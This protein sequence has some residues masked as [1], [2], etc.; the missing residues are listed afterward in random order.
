MGKLLIGLGTVVVVLVLAF[1]LY[2]RWAERWTSGVAPPPLA[3]PAS[4][5]RPAPSGGSVSLAQA[6]LAQEQQRQAAT[7]PSAAASA[8]PGAAT[9]P[10]APVA[11]SARGCENLLV[12]GTRLHAWW[13]GNG[14]APEAALVLR[15]VRPEGDRGDF[16]ASFTPAGSAAQEPV[17]GRWIG[18][19][20]FLTRP[21]SATS[22]GP[23][24]WEGGCRVDGTIRGRWS[25]AADGEGGAFRLAP[26]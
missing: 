9:D 22:A 19:R 4:M 6:R 15:E 5:P 14:P 16:T 20:V 2:A 3:G 13:R 10:A 8:V 11:G 23:Q 21:A 12:A 24:Q 1:V 7:D 18:D 26:P 17:R 25:S